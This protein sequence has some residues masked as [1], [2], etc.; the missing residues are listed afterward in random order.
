[1]RK[2]IIVG[3]GFDI[4]HDLRTKY[5]HFG[6]Y[7]EDHESE[8]FYLLENLY[9]VPNLWSDFE[10]NLSALN[11]QYLI[12][13]SSEGVGDEDD[14]H[15]MRSEAFIMDSANDKIDKL[16]NGL[17]DALCDWIMGIE[18]DKTNGNRFT[19]FSKNDDFITFNYSQT[20][21]YVYGI[22]VNSIIY[23]HNKA[24]GYIGSHN[25]DNHSD[26]VIGHNVK[27]HYDKQYRSQGNIGI[28]E[29]FCEDA[30]EES[31]RYYSELFKDTKSNFPKLERII[32]NAKNYNEIYILGHSLSDVDIEYFK[33]I[34]GKIPINASFYITYYGS[35]EKPV[36]EQKAKEF[37]H[38][39]SNVKFV[40][41][42]K[43]KTIITA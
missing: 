9:D 35:T 28:K 39:R 1:M 32:K 31:K 30:F 37:L 5:E 7:I 29:L 33:Y 40:D 24:V 36:I 38:S 17:R 15:P 43:Q 26:I 25:D 13:E 23:L 34:T 3:N 27:E 19:C 10:S 21:E 41:L 4:Y 14:E 18:Y 42:S 12:E 8:L 20:L 2:L 16:T 11:L 6:Q 22:N